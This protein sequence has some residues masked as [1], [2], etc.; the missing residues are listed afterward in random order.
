MGLNQSSERSA[1]E[2]ELSGLFLLGLQGE[3]DE[4][5][6]F[7]SVFSKYLRGYFFKKMRNAPDF[8]EDLVQEV[9][10]A[11]HNKRHTY[12]VGEP[13]TPW[14]HAIA[15]YKYVDFLRSKKN[16]HLNDSLEESQAIWV[17]EIREP[18][19]SSTDLTL[20]M[21]SLPQAHRRAIELTK[22]N[23]LSVKDAAQ[24][25]GLSESAIKVGVHRGLKKLAALIRKSHENA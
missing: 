23:G 11:V 20:L 10:I 17:E 12:E 5:K 25:S 1:L 16:E 9:L 14:L 24:V 6:Q 18:F 15:K 3:K 4:Y 2:T 7:L 8:V 13:L 22:I 19:E 21:F